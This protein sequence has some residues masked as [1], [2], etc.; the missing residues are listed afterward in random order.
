MK[1]RSILYR[2][3]GIILALSVLSGC[4]QKTKATS[5]EKIELIEPVTASANIEKVARRNLY[6][7]ETFAGVICPET[8]VYTFS[9]DVTFSHFE[10]FPG[11]QVYAGDVLAY[12][13]STQLMEEMEQMQESLDA[14][15]ESYEADL[16]VLAEQIEDVE[17]EIARREEWMKT[18]L[19]EAERLTREIAFL[20]LDLQALN[21]QCAARK[22]LYDL[23]YNYYAGHLEEL[24]AEGTKVSIRAKESGVVVAL[25]DYDNG[26]WVG[27][28][29]G[30]VAVAD[31]SVKRMR[32]EYITQDELSEAADVYAMIDGKR[33]EVEY[34]PYEQEEYESA[35]LAGKTLYSTFVIVDP[36]DEVEFGALVAIALIH[37]VER[38]ALSVPV[39]AL[40]NDEGGTY[41]YRVEDG[42]NV[43]AYIEEGYTDD[44]YVQVLSGVNEGDAI[45]L[46]DY[47]TL[48][49][50]TI[51]LVES[52]FSTSF[53]GGGHVVYPDYEVV[54]YDVEHGT[55]QFVQ[56][57]VQ[58]Y[59]TVQAGDLLATITVEGDDIL[60]QEKELQLQRMQERLLD[61]DEIIKDAESDM[62]HEERE[63]LYEEM[64]LA[65][66]DIAELTQEIE[67]LKADYATTK[68][69]ANASG[70]VIWLTDKQNG[71]PL[72][73][74]ENIAFIASSD[75]CYLEV[76][77][78]QYVLNYGNEMSIQ[79][80]GEGGQIV[81]IPTT[82][83]TAPT[84]ALSGEL[85]SELA[86]LQL[87]EEIL[88]R[89]EEMER[90]QT[91][92]YY[93]QHN[94][95]VVGNP[96]T[97]ANVILIPK[98]AVFVEEGQTYVYVLEENGDITARSFIAGGYDVENYWVLEGLEE[99]M[100]ICLE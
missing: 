29:S 42:E 87:P 9:D 37:E 6:E 58:R 79:Y 66:E 36:A 7:Y 16:K 75:T 30:V 1:K 23:D 94:Y 5:S 56:Y 77:N 15:T 55:G 76:S 45:L 50:E 11:E 27:E 12:A 25:G 20:E 93:E 64:V 100:T 86:Y 2:M 92:N 19:G 32:C 67:E 73:Y 22:A 13:D 18:A 63:D 40:H 34:I 91:G 70:I 88:A 31:E 52:E 68:I 48:G 14:I 28:S 33:Y 54:S 51:Q 21:D 69:Y 65:T 59:D 35:L 49:E 84:N 41:V 98:R 96:R 39:S 74:G 95:E 99:G 89:I 78:T 38:D 47:T 3:T 57:E 53:W 97:I 83:L 90:L 85:T 44:V 46:P 71:S 80:W 17:A 81:S 10:K 26:N 82:V 61:M 60:I 43:K 8:E 4:G 72:E 24:S 62:T